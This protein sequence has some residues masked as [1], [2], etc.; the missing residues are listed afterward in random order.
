MST[1]HAAASSSEIVDF[2]KDIL[3]PKFIQ[4]RR[5]PIGA[6]SHHSERICKASVSPPSARRKPLR[7]S[8]THSES[9]S[10]PVPAGKG[11]AL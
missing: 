3:V 11:E 9:H 5:I 7:A 10:Q 6:L 1:A 2:W 4:Y 8:L